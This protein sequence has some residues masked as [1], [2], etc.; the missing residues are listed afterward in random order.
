VALAEGPIARIGRIWADGKPFDPT[1]LTLRFYAGGEEQLPDSL[2]AAKE[3]PDAAPAYRGLAYVVFERLPLARFGNRLPQLSFEVFRPVGKAA[4]AVRAVNIIPGASEFGYDPE[5]VTRH[6][7]DGVTESENAHLLAG[8][9]DWSVSLDALQAACPNAAAVSLVVA[10]FGTDL[11]CG[12][13]ALRPGV[14]VPAK[15]TKP[16]TWKVAG[17]A[18]AAA[19]LV[20]SA[21]G[22]PAFGGTPS[23]ATVLRAI[24]DLKARGLAI[25]FSPF[26]LMDIPVDNALPD[27]YGATAQP[28]YPWRGRIT[29]DPAPGRPGSP[30]QTANLD[31]Q[32]AAFIGT[33]SPADFSVAD[34]EVAYS[35]PPEWSYR[36]MVLHY[37]KLC[38]LA[39]GVDTFLIGS[40]LR[41]L[42][43]LRNS[44]SHY[45]FVAALMQLAV[46]VKSILPQAAISY[47]AD[48][49]EYFGH[50]PQDGSGD[51]YFHLD[52]LW[53]APDIAFVGIDNYMPLSDWRD[54]PDHLDRLAGASAI[55]VTSY[56]RSNIAG[57]E[58]FDWYYA[59][60]ADRDA[61]QR[62][63][64][65]DGAHNKPWVFRYKD[66]V[67]WWSNPH[68]NRP[69][70]SEQGPATAWLPQS[71]PIRFTE[72]GCP[73]VDKGTNQPNVFVDP[74]S[75][76]N[77]L[78]YY[79]AGVGDGFLQQRYIE[80]VDG[81][82]RST[83][84]HNPV[85]AVYGGP[86]V[87]ADDIHYWAWDARPFPAFPALADVWR[88]GGNH[89][90]GHWLNGRI[91]ATPLGD[92]VQ[93][94]CSAYGVAEVEAASLSGLID[95]LTIERVGAARDLLEPL[96][97]AWTFDAVESQGLIRFR[98]KAREADLSLARDDLVD[99]D[100]EPLF[101]L[102]RTQEADLP[103][104]LKLAYRESG[105]DYRSAVVEAQRA[106]TVTAREI[107]LELPCAIAQEEAT[108]RAA[109]L[110]QETW[111]GRESLQLALP[112]SRVALDPGDVVSLDVNGSTRKIAIVE[113][114]DGS[115]RRITARR[116]DASLY[117]RRKAPVRRP[118]LV[119]PPLFGAPALA[120]LDLPLASPA[121]QPQAGWIAA[122]SKPWPGSLNLFRN[123]GGSFQLA[124]SLAAP[125]TMGE[126]V[127]PLARGPLAVF[128]RANVVQVRLWG[129][130]LFSVT[131]SQL[132]GGANVLAVG[133]PDQGFEILQFRDAELIAPATYALRHL[134]RGQSGSEPEMAELAPAGM[135]V[136]LLDA[137]VAQLEETLDDF[138]A[139]T[140]WRLGPAGRDHG[141]PAYVSFDH[142]VR[143][144]GLRPLHPVQ[145]RATRD[146]GDVVFTWIRRTRS[147]GDSWELAEVPLGEDREEYALDILAGGTPV[148]SLILGEAA[149]RYTAAAQ[150]QD[151]G[152]A[153]TSFTLRLAQISATFG[154]GAVLE[155]TLHV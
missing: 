61:Q 16:H 36:R 54:G 152:S 91:E 81:Y 70:G 77:A 149:Y 148:R 6:P 143:G 94:I 67:A 69:G 146:G 51:V 118:A 44:P 66:L 86:M 113:I 108:S 73:A 140:S 63:P 10:W 133:S 42:T 121:R 58:G 98:M 102:T 9:S 20:S 107:G 34:G 138:R 2:I 142:P 125:A 99:A 103:G 131:E 18:R 119:P 4:A 110:L 43:T 90:L 32:L 114:A 95:G 15:V 92:L 27:P 71:K 76:E 116:H 139:T 104:R 52:P 7:G 79:S 49:S 112:P 48:W 128:D 11:R 80:A 105:L 145:P 39:G 56:L 122:F 127:A 111:H 53:A 83:G 137:A 100:G 88:D 109:I 5:V 3:G 24:A 123:L 72:A 8:R 126:L 13:C 82:W 89:A 46:D 141:D 14:E 21:G 23:D 97:R 26:I 96:A 68:V 155:R 57:G 29:C 65:T 31:S 12:Q 41:G 93:D 129:G 45:P 30:D 47:A 85:S 50:Q 17:L 59:S 64:I 120:V 117:D 55:Y 25:T 151:F 106:G 101:T 28:P 87:A 132:L 144:L 135:L 136:V 78:P 150:Q 124:W 84:P 60:P 134:L 38:A 147:N 74:K 154:R 153:P 37:A 40:E 75:V 62:S 115:S 33:A 130:A 19:H 22:G 35:G 1:G